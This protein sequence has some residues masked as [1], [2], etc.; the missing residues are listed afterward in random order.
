MDDH[1]SLP[2]AIAA[3][4]DPASYPHPVERVDLVQTHISYVVLAGDYVYKLRKPVN[5]GFLDFTTLG[6]RRAD[7]RREVALNSRLCARLYLGVVAVRFDGR[8]YALDGRGR[9][10]DY[11][12]KMRRLPRERMMDALLEAGELTP[13][14]VGALAEL[15]AAFHAA[16]P[17]DRSVDRYGSIAVIR[18]NWEENFAQTERYVGRTIAPEQFACLRAWVRGTLRR[19][20][21][22]FRRRVA[23]G[24]IRDGHGDLRTSAVCFDAKGICVFDCIEFNRRFRCADVAADVAFLVMDLEFR[25]HAELAATFVERYVAASGDDGLRGLLPFYACYR[26]YVR[27]KVE[28]FRLDEPEVGEDDKRAAAEIARRSFA[29]ACR[30]ADQQ[31]LPLLVLVCGLSGSGKSTLA[32]RLAAELGAELES[33]DVVRK[34]LAGVPPTEHR[35]G[36]FR[37]GLY[38]PRMTERVYAEL[39]QRAER[40]LAAG[41]SV[42][43]DATF[44]ARRHRARALALA[45]RAGAHA[46]CIECRASEAVI[47]QRMLQREHDPNVVSDARWETYLAQR[48]TFEPLDDV[49]ARR[50]VVVD[51]G[52]ALDQSLTAALAAIAARFQCAG[53]TV[54]TR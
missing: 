34:A 31:P 3:L 30:Y 25:G 29:L 8:R 6:K 45:E 24:R 18:R 48:A 46:L 54:A 22:T 51:T 44:G 53:E 27:G 37:R 49:D 21:G 32:T 52:Q 19:E 33:S 10:V 42:V 2:A 40:L 15:I 17:H 23:Q 50:H 1:A 4:L 43:L 12:V 47:Y 36:L 28:S 9:V 13:E 39:T 5:F 38:T 35:A 26:A 14:M 11:A 41:R 16:A 7:C 20:R